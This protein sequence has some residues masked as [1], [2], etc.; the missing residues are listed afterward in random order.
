MQ[1]LLLF[2]MEIHVLQEIHFSCIICSS[3][4][5]NVNIHVYFVLNV[6]SEE[7]IKDLKLKACIVIMLETV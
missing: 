7:D 4:V 5:T 1:Q 6:Q 2:Y 3:K